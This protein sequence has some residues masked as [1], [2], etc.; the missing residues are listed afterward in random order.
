MENKNEEIRER[1]LKRSMDLYSTKGIKNL[2]MDD[3]AGDL[4]I[5]KK[6]IY[7][8]FPNKEELIKEMILF[9]VK[10]NIVDFETM[11]A[12]YDNYLDL[13]YDSMIGR[14]KFLQPLIKNALDLRKYYP[15]I[16][17][18]IEE[19]RAGEAQKSVSFIQKAMEKGQIRNDIEPR[20]VMMIAFSFIINLIEE[21]L[22]NPELDLEKAF[23]TFFGVLRD[24]LVPRK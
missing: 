20:F 23:S 3:V 17:G 24:G 13:F 9:Y 5:S 11:A 1:I 4:G 21:K 10:S 8:I 2:I 15:K 19:L 6:T 14:I 18:M 22:K 12:T 16:W 7:K